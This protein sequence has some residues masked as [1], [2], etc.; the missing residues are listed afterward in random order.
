MEIDKI[1]TYLILYYNALGRGSSP[2]SS[3]ARNS[4][5]LSQSG[6]CGKSG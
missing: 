6:D 1:G 2:R 4:P 5:S 3:S